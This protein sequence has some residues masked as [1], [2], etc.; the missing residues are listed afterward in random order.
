MIS[1]VVKQ[2]LGCWKPHRCEVCQL[3]ALHLKDRTTY[4]VVIKEVMRNRSCWDR[5]FVCLYREVSKVDDEGIF[6]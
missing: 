2:S 1:N 5:L 6:L 4:M 3:L